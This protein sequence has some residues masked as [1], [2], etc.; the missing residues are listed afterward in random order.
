MVLWEERGWGSKGGRAGGWGT[1][2]ALCS[3]LNGTFQGAQSCSSQGAPCFQDYPGTWLHL[4]MT[5][6]DVKPRGPFCV[7]GTMETPAH[8]PFEVGS[9]GFCFRDCLLVCDFLIESLGGH[10]RKLQGQQAQEQSTERAGAQGLHLA[11]LQHHQLP[12]TV[13]AVPGLHRAR[14]NHIY[15]KSAFYNP[16]EALGVQPCPSHSHSP[17]ALHCS[18][19]C[20]L[21]GC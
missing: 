21:R 20:C 9:L 12:H 18:L 19:I 3:H 7:P 5:L 15:L 17:G 14:C 16:T 2:E 11:P 10:R 13:T 8:S 1:V 6:R 4:P